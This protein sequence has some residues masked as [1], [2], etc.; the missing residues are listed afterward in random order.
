MP[1]GPGIVSSASSAPVTFQHAA[2]IAGQV[3]GT[4]RI[5]KAAKGVSIAVTPLRRLTERER[6]EIANA[7]ARYESFREVPVDLSID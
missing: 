7:A 4:W 5:V 3:A 6:R 1:H 2:V